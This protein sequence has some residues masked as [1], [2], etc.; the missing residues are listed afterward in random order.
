MTALD[1]ILVQVLGIASVEQH[2][3]LEELGVQ[4][5]SVVT[6][7]QGVEFSERLGKRFDE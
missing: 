1:A 5:I 3:G 2:L 7:A 6:L 4:S